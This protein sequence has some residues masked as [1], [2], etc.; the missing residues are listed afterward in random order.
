MFSQ[1]LKFIFIIPIKSKKILKVLT[2]VS[3]GKFRNTICHVVN[4]YPG[5]RTY[6]PYLQVHM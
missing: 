6:L 1:T 2:V 4:T 3:F 5:M